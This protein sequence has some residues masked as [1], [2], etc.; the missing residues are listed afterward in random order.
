MKLIDNEVGFAA[1]ESEAGKLSEPA[2]AS[3]VALLATTA[4]PRRPSQSGA[5]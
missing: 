1:L 5:C 4:V 2:R 3:L